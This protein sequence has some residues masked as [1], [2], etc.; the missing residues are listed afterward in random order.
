MPHISVLGTKMFLWINFFKILLR[1]LLPSNASCVTFSIS[2]STLLQVQ[3][4]LEASQSVALDSSIAR[5]D[6]IFCHVST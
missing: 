6:P 1:W 4:R 5:E 2:P 3:N